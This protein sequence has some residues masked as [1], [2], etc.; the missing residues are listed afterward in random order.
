MPRVPS[1]S[2][3]SGSFARL[4]WLLA[5]LAATLAGS[6]TLGKSVFSAS[7]SDT[8]GYVAAAAAVRQRQLVRPAPWQLIPAIPTAFV[9]TS[10]LAFTRGVESGTEVPQ[11]PLGLPYLMAA[12]ASA[13]GP[14]GEFAVTPA[15]FGLLVWL[16]FLLA[17]D[18]GGD[19][20]GLAAAAFVASDP[21]AIL[22]G[23]WSLSDAPAAACWIGAWYLS[24]RGTVGAALA[25]GLTASMAVMIRPGLVPLMLVPA[26]TSLWMGARVTRPSTWRLG[27][28]LAFGAA[29]AVG[30]LMVAWS[31]TVLYGSPWRSGYPTE[32]LFSVEHVWSNLVGYPPLY[33]A[34]HGGIPLLAAWLPPVLFRGMEARQRALV[35]SGLGIIAINV[36][37]FLPYSPYHE[38]TYLRFFLPATTVVF[39]F[40]GGGLGR[41]WG[42][43]AGGRPLHALRWG[44]PVVALLAGWQG[45][46]LTA[47]AMTEQAS[48]A[49]IPMMGHYLRAALP[50]NA[51]VLGYLHGGAV[52]HYTGRSVIGIE[53][54]SGTML[55]DLVR[56][57][58]RHGQHPVFV[59]DEHFED[60][61]FLRLFAGSEFGRL[62]WPPRAQFVSGTRIR[63]FDPADRMRWIAGARWPTDVLR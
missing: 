38:W 58:Q 26:A 62:D 18:L 5:L 32:S 60:A 57:L 2:A 6:V 17:R 40:A 19:A 21:V 49:R 54:M 27:R 43:W 9:S 30:G 63:Y 48:H 34:A 42:M 7:I 50:P 14:L 23:V 10:P 51:I 12:F 4:P 36:A 8:S 46:D 24:L 39:V 37:V 55:D 29:G 59:L 47:W 33:L 28:A 16:A 20:A 1:P 11:Y 25:A 45:R 53:S 52:A 22:N 61:T 3:P 13:L 41:V 56:L 15:M 31:H 35:V 44:L